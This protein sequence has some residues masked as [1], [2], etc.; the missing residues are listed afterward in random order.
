MRCL[1]NIKMSNS[2]FSSLH[3]LILTSCLCF[4]KLIMLFFNVWRECDSWSHPWLT[5]SLHFLKVT[6]R[7]IWYWLLLHINKVTRRKNIY[8]FLDYRL[9][10]S[11]KCINFSLLF[12]L[13]KFCKTGFILKLCWCIPHLWYYHFGKKK[14][15][16]S[17]ICTIFF[18]G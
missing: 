14:Y 8:Y 18:F 1:K 6:S 4:I 10:E 3:Y 13:L 2:Q 9:Y 17:F 7:E 16:Y 11:Y 12:N 15:I 5:M